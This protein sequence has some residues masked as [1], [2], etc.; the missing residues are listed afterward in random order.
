MCRH[1]AI[2]YL[3]LKLTNF[4][5]VTLVSMDDRAAASDPRQRVTQI[6]TD[7]SPTMTSYSPSEE[8]SKSDRWIGPHLVMDPLPPVAIMQS[9][10]NHAHSRPDTWLTADIGR[11]I[12]L[13]TTFKIR[14]QW[15]CGITGGNRSSS[16][17]S[18]HNPKYKPNPLLMQIHCLLSM[19]QMI[20]TTIK[21][22]ICRPL[23][24]R[25]T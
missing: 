6:K 14:R 4:F 17:A 15:V 3:W 5:Q 23:M 22:N 19:C 20:S 16:E 7:W 8:W 11:S 18:N 24:I 10:P 21:K 25:K 12:F 2:F 13:K 9:K 1:R